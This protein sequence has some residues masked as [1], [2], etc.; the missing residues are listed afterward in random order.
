M[1]RI[2]LKIAKEIAELAPKPS[3]P[4]GGKP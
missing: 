4:R 3:N 2:F 1:R